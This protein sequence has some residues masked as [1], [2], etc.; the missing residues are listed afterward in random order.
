M[1]I[2]HIDPD[3]I[4]NP[5]AGGGPVRTFEICRRLAERHE[6]TVLTP[7]FPGSTPTKVR[8]NVR[9]L[10]VGRRVGDHGSSHHITFFFAV[11]WVARQLHYDLLVEDFM[12]PTA[13]T[14]LPLVARG[15]IVASVQ[16][17]MAETLSRQ[18]HLPFWLGERYGVKL[19]RNFVVLADSMKELLLE[20]NPH[21]RCEVIPNA[22][23]ES[24]FD[25]PIEPGKGVLFL[26]RIDFQQK[27]VDLLLEAWTHIPA[28]ARP[29]LT[30]AGHTHIEA[31]L[32]A[33]LQR[34]GLE[35]CVRV[36]GRVDAAERA[37]LLRAA[38]L[39]CIPSRSETFGM[40]ILE[41]CAAGK[42][43]VVFDQSPMNE[44][45][46]K[47]ASLRVTPYSCEELAS[48]VMQ[49]HAEDDATLLRKGN[50]ARA[51]A[52]LHSWDSAARHQENFYEQIAGNA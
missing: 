46:P 1:R 2:L 30:L 13:A 26:G 6:V 49:L 4:D 33:R 19:Y 7:T 45:A 3:D 21:A 43:V 27:G 10:R 12:P 38:R 36:T 17:F 14:L 8:D 18:Y 50:I 28:S 29:S 52:R 40:V 25:I 48:A 5:L 31:E 51:H 47:G 39:V 9:Y 42:P 35:S 15:P 34:L 16:W 24:L 37:R 22:V 11:P 32:H 20:R 44:V 23:D 41:A